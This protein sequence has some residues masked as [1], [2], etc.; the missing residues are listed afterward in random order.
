MELICAACQAALHIAD[1]RVP[2]HITSRVTC[3]RCKQKIDVSWKSAS[4]RAG[5]A[6]TPSAAGPLLAETATST[7]L[8]GET[9]EAFQPGQP[10]ALLCVDQEEVRAT[11]KPLLKG[12]GYKVDCPPTPDHALQHLRFNQC[13][14]IVVDDAFGG[15]APNPV[16][17][18]LANLNMSTR[19][20]MVVVLL[21][22]RLK[23]ADHWQAF[24]ESV[25]LVCHPID[26]RQLPAVLKR[27]VSEHEHFYRLFNECLI[28]AGKKI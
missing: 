25:D 13:H 17:S 5:T 6:Y 16:A 26:V 1:E 14:L 8:P 18:Y 19:R 12:M 7:E 28:A 10:M 27:T 4:N 11:L 23:T 2:S 22:E 20:D 9:I 21:G 24:V 15:R 3:P